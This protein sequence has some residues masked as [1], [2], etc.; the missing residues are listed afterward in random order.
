MLHYFQLFCVTYTPKWCATEI[1]E[2]VQEPA[3]KMFL[4]PD[5]GLVPHL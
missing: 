5:G 4:S 2:L 1:G 3:E